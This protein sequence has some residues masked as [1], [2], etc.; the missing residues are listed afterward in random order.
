MS[1]Q[2][3]EGGANVPVGPAWNGVSRAWVA[4]TLTEH[5]LTI[6]RC[7]CGWQIPHNAPMLPAHEIHVAE[8]LTTPPATPTEGGGDR[9]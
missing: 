6:G 5:R 4:K 1:E 9:G 2:T 3:G 7:T 8:V